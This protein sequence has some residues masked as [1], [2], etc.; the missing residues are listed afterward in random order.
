[1]S[2]WYSH[3]LSCPRCEHPFSEM[4]A[5]GLHAK[6]IPQVRAQILQGELHQVSCPACASPLEIHRRI[7]YTDFDRFQW[8]E[9][10]VPEERAEWQRVEAEALAR[11]DRALTGAA[12]VIQP[13]R[14]QFAVRVVFDLDEL[15]ERLVIW[16]AGLDDGLVECL[17]LHCLAE[18][19]S[20]L[21][22]QG[23]IRVREIKLD[24]AIVMASI[25]A[26]APR[27]ARAE[28]TVPG[29]FARAMFTDEGVLRARYPELFGRG[30][31]SI[32]RYWLSGD[33]NRT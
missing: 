8:V 9:V 19:P 1:M 12:P 23:R 31:V 18:R 33:G 7:A 4:L 13:L 17:K 16:D 27:Q 29:D 3:E 10:A 26:G 32:E 14:D 28:W 25:H 15:R 22:E 21:A 30:F 20:L 6:R 5:A 2:T 11:F 24:G